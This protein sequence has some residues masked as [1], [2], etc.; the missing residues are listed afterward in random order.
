[1][2]PMEQNRV[3]WKRSSRLCQ[4]LICNVKGLSGCV[5]NDVLG[6]EETSI[7]HDELVE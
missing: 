3:V 4:I 7:V 2:V 6:A 5:R 1:M